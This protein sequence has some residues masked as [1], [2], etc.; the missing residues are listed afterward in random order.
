MLG[1]FVGGMILGLAR[2][3][4]GY[5]L[6]PAAQ[7]LILYLLVLVVLAARPQGIFGVKRT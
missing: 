2:T 1:T 5:L 6:D 4:G 3:L 7:T